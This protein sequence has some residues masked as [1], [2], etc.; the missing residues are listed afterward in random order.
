MKGKRNNPNDITKSLFN[1]QQLKGFIVTL[2]KNYLTHTPTINVKT[3][4][5]ETLED[6]PK[7]KTEVEIQA[8][9]EDGKNN[10]FYNTTTEQLEVWIGT[11]RRG[12]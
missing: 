4:N 1:L 3:I 9:I 10:F 5:I 7:S 2:I 11:T 8:I 12:I 6:Y